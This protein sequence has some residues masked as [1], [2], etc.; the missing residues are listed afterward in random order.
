ML[1]KTPRE[2]GISAFHRGK[3]MRD[4]P[5]THETSRQSANFWEWQHGYCEQARK[6]AADARAQCRATPSAQ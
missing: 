2:K 6:E 3:L 1:A 4:N 5:Y